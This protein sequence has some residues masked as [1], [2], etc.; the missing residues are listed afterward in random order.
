MMDW[1]NEAY[2]RVYTRDTADYQVLSWQARGL[3]LELLRKADRSGV[4]QTAH[5]TRGIAALLRWPVDVIE[6]ALGELLKDGCVLASESPSGLVI[7]NFIDAQEAKK[8]DRLRQELSRKNRNVT[9]RD[10]SVTKRDSDVTKRDQTSQPVTGGHAVSQ[11]VTLCCALPSVALQ[12]IAVLK[13]KRSASPAPP[14]AQLGIDSFH[15]YFVRTHGG[16]KPSW[17]PRN[18]KRMHDLVRVRGVE[19]VVRRLEILESSPPKWPDPPW[20]LATFVQHFDKVAAPS[21]STQ[22]GLQF[23]LGVA[24][25]ATP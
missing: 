17:D 7:P 12:G 19:T 21:N 18:L 3:W 1:S 23:A 4:I 10:S 22:S 11:D 24:S 8:S 25:G 14:G 13:K 15:S 9:S 6:P 16:E 20:D 2:V 5:G